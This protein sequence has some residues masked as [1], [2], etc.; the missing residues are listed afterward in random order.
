MRLDARP[1]DRRLRPVAS[2]HATATGAQ[3]GSRAIAATAPSNS[4]APAARS[5]AMLF[6]MLL[7]STVIIT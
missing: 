4:A 5:L 6:F 7:S 1:H 2:I 3:T